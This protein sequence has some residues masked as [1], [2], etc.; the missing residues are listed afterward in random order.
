MSWINACLP[1]ALG[2]EP[3][4]TARC[5]VARFIPMFMHTLCAT[6][7]ITVFWMVAWKNTVN[8]VVLENINQKKRKTSNYFKYCVFWHVLT[9]NHGYLQCCLPR[10]CK[11]HKYIANTGAVVL[12]V[13]GIWPVDARPLQHRWCAKHCEAPQ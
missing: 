3:N 7:Q 8:T 4:L 5:K 11:K 9:Q 12:D 13:F 1:T 10:W 2:F 6:R